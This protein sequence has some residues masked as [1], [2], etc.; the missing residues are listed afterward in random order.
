[1]SKRVLL[2][3]KLYMHESKFTHQ[4]KY[5]KKMFRGREK[6]NKHCLVHVDLKPYQCCTC[7]MKF[8]LH[9]TAWVHVKKEHD[10]E[11]KIVLCEKEVVYALRKKLVRRID[12]VKVDGGYKYTRYKD[13]PKI[14]LS[15]LNELNFD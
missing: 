7:Q 3:H 14:D 13:I 9:S 12:P 6:A 11:A 4:C 5:C 1:M 10:S 15:L 8:Q 2:K